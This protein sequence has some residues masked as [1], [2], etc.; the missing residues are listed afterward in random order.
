MIKQLD[1]GCV[2]TFLVQ[3]GCVLTGVAPLIPSL[4]RGVAINLF[5][6]GGGYKFFGRY[7][8]SMLMFNSRCDVI[9]TP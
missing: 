3:Q 6:W 9:S 4:I 8:T 1:D 7:K 5:F 2:V